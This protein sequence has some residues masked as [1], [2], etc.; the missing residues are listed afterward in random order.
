MRQ[1]KT[2]K[3][4]QLLTD[5]IY[6]GKNYEKSCS[7]GMHLEVHIAVDRSSAKYIHEHKA[8]GHVAS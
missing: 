1:L 3:E 8:I 5:G 4:F 6:G 2:I 7:M